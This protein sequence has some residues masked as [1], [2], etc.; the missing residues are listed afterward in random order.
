MIVLKD[1]FFWSG[2]F[3]FY[4]QTDLSSFLSFQDVVSDEER[5]AQAALNFKNMEDMSVPVILNIIG[6]RVTE[7]KNENC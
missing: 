7:K 5:L 2:R 1:F 6:K 3:F 4:S